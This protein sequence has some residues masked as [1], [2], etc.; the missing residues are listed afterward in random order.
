MACGWGH[1]SVVGGFPVLEAGEVAV[2]D[3]ISCLVLLLLLVV[4][5]PIRVGV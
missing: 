4:Q 3:N 1:L 2:K 5:K